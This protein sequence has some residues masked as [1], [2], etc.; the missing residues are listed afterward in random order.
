MHA[1]VQRRYCVAQLEAGHRVNTTGSGH[2]SLCQSQTRF[3]S[4]IET[5]AV[6]CYTWSSVISL[7]VIFVSPA[8]TA[9]L[10]EMPFGVLIRVDQRNHVLDE[11][12]DR[13]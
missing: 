10:I 2:V 11:G 8:K 5:I 4:H 12:A 9:E 6:Y 1:A 7:S 3:L 13:Q